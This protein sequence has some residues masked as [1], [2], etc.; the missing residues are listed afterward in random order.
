LKLKRRIDQQIDDF[1]DEEPALLQLPQL[2]KP[3][4]SNCA[5][6]DAYLELIPGTVIQGSDLDDLRCHWATIVNHLS[7]IDVMVLT[8]K[9]LNALKLSAEAASENPF[10]DS[11]VPSERIL[12]WIT[13][14][15]VILL[16]EISMMIDQPDLDLEV[17]Y[18][19]L[20]PNREPRY[21]AEIVEDQIE[22]LSRWRNDMVIEAIDEVF[23][24]LELEFRQARDAEGIE[25][26]EREMNATESQDLSNLLHRVQQYA[27][28]T[29]RALRTLFNTLLVS[30][31]ATWVV[32]DQPDQ[33][34]ERNIRIY[35]KPKFRSGV[36]DVLIGS[37]AR[38]IAMD[39]TMPLAAAQHLDRIMGIPFTRV[40][41]GDPMKS[42]DLMKIVPWPIEIKAP[43]IDSFV[44]EGRRRDTNGPRWLDSE[45]LGAFELMNKFWGEEF[46]VAVPSKR[47]SNYIQQ[48]TRGRL[49]LDLMWHRGSESVGVANEKR[50]MIGLAAP[51]APRGALNWHKEVLYPEFLADMDND[52][53]WRYDQHKT[54]YQTMSR[55]KDPRF[56]PDLS[57]HRRSVYIAFG[58]PPY[59][60][61][62]LRRDVVEPPEVIPPA[63]V[64]EIGGAKRYI[65]PIVTA[66]FWTELGLELS[67][68]DQHAVYHLWRGREPGWIIRNV[69]ETPPRNRVENLDAIVRAVKIDRG[70][71]NDE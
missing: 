34:A 65:T 61:E 36:R 13:E 4:C 2:K 16:D 3:S 57:T 39:A 56:D 67:V 55:I 22:E 29:N 23:E 40:N 31:E 48:L 8:H 5:Y 46:I 64:R 69:P 19:P 6:R 17:F 52:D 43:Q 7:Q 33:D 25:I 10:I 50:V 45:L 58:Q 71:S 18:D 14:S 59:L 1:P 12:D 9:K 70:I 49:N 27:A 41:I 47:S 35:I 24:G 53:I 20:D 63:Q 37:N 32:L 28:V 42:A 60:I 51:F 30:Q 44:Q 68:E 21:V 38:I 11:I 66:F 15:K 54:N 62:A 26:Y